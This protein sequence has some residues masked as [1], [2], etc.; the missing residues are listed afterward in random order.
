VTC[1]VVA[2]MWTCSERTSPTASSN[3]AAA[4]LSFGSEVSSSS[5]DTDPSS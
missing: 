1:R 3:L 5:Y 4:A 2:F